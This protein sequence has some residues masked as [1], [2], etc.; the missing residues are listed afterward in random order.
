MKM[1]RFAGFA[2]F[3]LLALVA[4]ASIA[5]ATC[6]GCD[7]GA[8]FDY[9]AGGEAVNEGTAHGGLTGV[10][11]KSNKLVYGGGDATDSTSGYPKANAYAGSHFSTQGGS[12][13]LSGG[14]GGSYAA[15]SEFGAVQ[16]GGS[17]NAYKFR[18]NN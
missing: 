9:S 5:S 3:S 4:S 8:G 12:M 18:T 13:A 15:T 6:W 1:K 10:W 14:F 7:N 16:G 2:G 11:S 17:A